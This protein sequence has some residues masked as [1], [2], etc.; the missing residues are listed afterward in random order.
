VKTHAAAQFQR[1]R[2]VVGRPFMAGCELADDGEFFVDVEQLV[3]Q[4]REHDAADEGARQCRIER[5]GVFGETDAQRLRRCGER[6]TEQRESG[7]GLAQ[8]VEAWVQ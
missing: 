4:R 2:L 5:V 8:R 6:G 7:Q 3:A 1:Q